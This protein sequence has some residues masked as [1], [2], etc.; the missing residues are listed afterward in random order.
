M[1]AP[2]P[3]AIAA[4][5]IGRAASV[6]RPDSESPASSNVKGSEGSAL[7]TLASAIPVRLSGAQYAGSAP[8]ARGGGRDPQTQASYTA[9]SPAYC[10]EPS[11]RAIRWRVLFDTGQSLRGAGPGPALAL[12]PAHRRSDY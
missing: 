12:E 1:P 7:S 11:T 3:W 4:T 5:A 6:Q 2:A 8:E 9:Q 10:P